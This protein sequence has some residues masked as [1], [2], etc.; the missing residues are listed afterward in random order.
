MKGKKI[1]IHIVNKETAALGRVKS[2]VG[3]RRPR[4]TTKISNVGFF[5][6]IV[7]ALCRAATVHI[8]IVLFI[9]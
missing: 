4:K 3:Q 8:Y 1:K 2:I 9:L 5:F 7:K 6:F